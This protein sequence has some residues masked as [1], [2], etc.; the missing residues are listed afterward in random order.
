MEYG[1]DQANI[2]NW[3]VSYTEEELGFVDNVRS[4]MKI[5]EFNNQKNKSEPVTFEQLCQIVQDTT[6]DSDRKC[7]IIDGS[8][9]KGD[10]KSLLRSKLYNDN[11]EAVENMAAKDILSIFTSERNVWVNII[12]RNLWQ[13][14]ILQ[15]KEAVES[16]KGGYQLIIRY[17]Y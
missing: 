7:V 3:T 8:K 2:T 10:I 13:E 16:F 6:S 17:D 5:V 9:E 15:L 1:Q 14:D 4:W 11:L 12:V